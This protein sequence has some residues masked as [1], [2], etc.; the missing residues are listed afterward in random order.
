MMIKAYSSDGGTLRKVAGG[1]TVATGARNDW[2]HL[3]LVHDLSA[4]TLEVYVDGKKKWSG[5]GGRGGS[6]NVKYGN[7]GTG[8]PAQVQWRNVSW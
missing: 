1:V 3:R 4:D 7:Y 2:V 5:S 8:A 6:F